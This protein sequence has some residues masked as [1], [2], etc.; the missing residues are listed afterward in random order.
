GDAEHAIRPRYVAHWFTSRVGQLRARGLLILYSDQLAR[1][2]EPYSR[3]WTRSILAIG[4]KSRPSGL[5]CAQTSHHTSPVDVTVRRPSEMCQ[6][7]RR[8]R[9]HPSA[10]AIASF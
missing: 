2:Q 1:C 6:P 10:A 9:A 5:T 4:F 8:H 3:T 7:S